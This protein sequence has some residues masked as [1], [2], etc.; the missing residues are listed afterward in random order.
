MALV[1]LSGQTCSGKRLVQNA[2]VE[3]GYSKIVTNTT[4]KPK[5]GEDYNYLSL[6]MFDSLNKK[7]SLIATD[8]CRNDWFGLSIATML[9]VLEENPNAVIC[10]TPEGAK[11]LRN[12]LIANKMPH[13]MAFI[14]GDMQTIVGELT[15]RRDENSLSNNDYIESLVHLIEHESKWA[16]TVKKQTYFDICFDMATSSPNEIALVAETI[17]KHVSQLNQLP[18]SLKFKATESKMA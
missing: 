15:K 17:D 4:R 8:K 9:D 3:M 18:S 14:D 12:Y 7:G 10:L 16:E 6:E 1:I 5:E 2:L 11:K 13:V